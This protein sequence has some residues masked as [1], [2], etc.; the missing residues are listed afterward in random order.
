MVLFCNAIHNAD[1]TDLKSLTDF[2][3]S[4]EPCQTVSEGAENLYKM[5]FLFLKIAEI[6]IEAKEKEVQ[7]T[8]TRILTHQE[9]YHTNEP[10]TDTVYHSTTAQFDPH[11]RALGLGCNPAGS[12]ANSSPG[13]TFQARSSYAAS[14]GS[15]NLLG[16]QFRD[17]GYASISTYPIFIQ[18]CF[19]GP[20][21][22]INFINMEIDL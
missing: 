19:L 11:L 13:R 18:D 20:R 6:Y 15:A 9:P 8:Q 22:P 12:S 16:S 5:C 3:S 21:Y 17:P 2:V 4:L 7:D 14:Q 1:R 10:A